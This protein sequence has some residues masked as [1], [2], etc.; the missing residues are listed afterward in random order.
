M[1]K[2]EEFFLESLEWG[3]AIVESLE[4]NTEDDSLLM[5]A[6][7]FRRM[8]DHMHS[9]KALFN[10][11]DLILIARSVYEGFLNLEYARQEQLCKKWRLYAVILDQ[12][13][14]DSGKIPPEEVKAAIVE[15]LDEAEKLFPK[16]SKGEYPSSWKGRATIYQMAKK[17]GEPFLTL[18][19]EDYDYMSDY[20]HW[21]LQSLGGG[22]YQFDKNGKILKNQAIDEVLLARPLHLMLA[23]FFYMAWTFA[24]CRSNNKIAKEATQKC[25]IAREIYLDFMKGNY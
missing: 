8:I 4:T 14:I 6:M 3:E 18:Y 24:Y 13:K 5:Q 17:L 16:D 19:R 22:R 1:N 9:A 23:S 11:S 7:F 10:N 25:L 12:K 15:K 20:H 21:G 2:L